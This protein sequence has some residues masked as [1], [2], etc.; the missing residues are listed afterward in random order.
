MLRKAITSL[1][2]AV[3]VL[4]LAVAV[5]A[6]GAGAAGVPNHGQ[7]SP[8][9]ASARCVVPDLEVMRISEAKRTLR[10]A[11][12]RPGKVKILNGKASR[13]VVVRQ[14]PRPGVVL[15]AGTKVNIA[16]VEIKST[17]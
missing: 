2:L 17:A 12:C 13:A 11:H 5:L 9:R 16:A 10:H 7:T 14:H 3:S 15:K 4:A 1:A 6:C 8:E